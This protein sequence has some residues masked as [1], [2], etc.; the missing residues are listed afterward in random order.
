M[1]GNAAGEGKL[2]E[3]LFH[4]FFVAADVR[5][6]LA[7]ASVQVGIGNQKVSAVSR[8][9]EQDHIQIVALDGAVAVDVHEILSGY[10]SPVTD[11]FFLDLVH[12]KGFTQQRIVQQVELSGGEIVCR[13]PVSVHFFQHFLG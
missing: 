1:A 2:L 12:G 10:G 7:V 4:T 13:T 3:H 5:I 8:P 6:N 11:D 9:G